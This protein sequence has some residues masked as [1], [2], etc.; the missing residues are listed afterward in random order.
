MQKCLIATIDCRISDRVAPCTGVSDQRSDLKAAKLS[1]K[2]CDCSQAAKCRFG[3]G[4]S[5]IR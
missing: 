5:C 2:S 3:E 4:P 1:E